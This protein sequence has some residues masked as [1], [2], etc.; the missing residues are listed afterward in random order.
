MNCAGD[1]KSNTSVIDTTDNNQSSLEMYEM[2]SPDKNKPNIPHF[3]N[4]VIGMVQAV[5]GSVNYK[6]PKNLTMGNFYFGQGRYNR[7]IENYFLNILPE[8]YTLTSDKNES[9]IGLARCFLRLGD[10]SSS[11]SYLQKA[12]NFYKEKE[13]IELT[14]NELFLELSSKIKDLYNTRLSKIDNSLDL[15]EFIGELLE[16]KSGWDLAI[17]IVEFIIGN[18]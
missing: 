3:N 9:L 8:K 1:P 2:Y 13:K 6:G 18:N 7:A 12:L 15:Y 5:S 14:H 17:R 4:Q 10:I 11:I 16:N